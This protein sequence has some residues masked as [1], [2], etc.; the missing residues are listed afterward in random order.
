MLRRLLL[1]NFRNYVSLDLQCGSPVNV[2]IGDNGQG[3]TNLLEAIYY[4]SYLRSFRTSSLNSLK[5]FNSKSFYV[6]AE[7]DNYSNWHS[8]FEVE[9]SDT[10]S[11]KIDGYNTRKTSDFVMSS[12]PVVF[13]HDD[14]EI[15]TGGSST[16]RKFFD[17]F[18]S[19]IDR[20]YLILLKEFVIAL[21]SRN[22]I[23]RESVERKQSLAAFESIMAVRAMEIIK[24]RKTIV[25]KITEKA[26][27]HIKEI[28][29]KE[30]EFEVR[31]I[32]RIK[33]HDLTYEK[34]LK[35]LEQDRCK[36]HAKGFTGC[37]PHM[38]EFDFYYNRM[39]LKTYGSL[40][41]CR[42]GAISLKMATLD[43]LL[44][45]TENKRKVVVLVDDVTGELDKNT[46]EAFFRDISPVEQVFFA[47]TKNVE[48]RH[49]TNKIIHRVKDG[50]I[51]KC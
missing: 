24:R 44:E 31:Y 4:L 46:K 9:V 18:L 19:S 43:L 29:G 49:L 13:K 45:S 42:I 37:G 50:R 1:R 6:A 20:N 36:D 17:I 32:P 23:I 16:R 8:L 30:S 26:C 25:E 21:K 48:E 28:K 7:I 34:I 40:G 33:E 39:N 15:I 22:A 5:Y 10:K 38:D 27:C 41:Q 14:M 51:E 3:K 2:F 35:C 47:V 12:L 11:L